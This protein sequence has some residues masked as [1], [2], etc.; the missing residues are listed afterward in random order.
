MKEADQHP[1]R[2]APM[3]LRGEG[4][5]CRVRQWPSSPHIAHLVLYQQARLPTA[6]ELRRWCDELAAAGFQ[7]VRTSAMNSSA[8]GRVAS[9]GFSSV[10]DL[11]LLQHDDP[12]SAPPPSRPTTR[13][14]VAQH[15]LASEVDVAAFGPTWSLDPEAITDVCHATPRHRGRAAGGASLHAYAITGRDSR[16]GF[17]QRLAVDPAHQGQGLGRDLVLDSLRWLARWRV[18]TVLVNTPTT[19]EAALR[20]YERLG[21]R[22]LHDQLCVF[23]RPLR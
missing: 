16:Q 17:L 20:L 21:F 8:G 3:V 12:R 1:A 9:A 14:L 13:L 4:V 18:S 22:R 6:D 19:N 5:S 11:A 7:A 2:P 23:E 15:P 10:Q